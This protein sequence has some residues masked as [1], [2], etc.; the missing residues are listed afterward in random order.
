[1]KTLEFFFD[2][3][4]PAAFLA[5]TQLARLAQDTNATI[6]YRPMLLGAV[7]KATGNH[8]PAM[9]PAKGR[10]M[11]ED[12]ARFA[13]RYGQAFTMN[14][15]FPINT[16]YLMRAATAM[17]LYMPQ[18]LE[19][20]IRAIYQALWV[21]QLNLGD[22]ATL[23]QVLHQNGFSPQTLNVWLE[24]DKVKETLKQTTDEAVARG[25]FGAPT[26]FVGDQMFFGQDR[27]DFVKEALRT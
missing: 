2:F 22:Q 14:P 12:L 7:F 8:S 3:G 27:L 21:D 24:D 6:H 23:D 19:R 4:S 25:V 18:E 13:K 5:W 17:S 11:S 20:F 10:Y 15:Y 9:I 26:F 16:L 1:M